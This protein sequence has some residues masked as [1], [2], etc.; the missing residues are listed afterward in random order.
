MRRDWVHG[1]FNARKC[2]RY[3]RSIGVE[4]LPTEVTRWLTQE[5]LSRK[6]RR[7]VCRREAYECGQCHA[8]WESEFK[9]RPKN[10]CC[11]HCGAAA[12]QMWLLWVETGDGERRT[13]D[14]SAWGYDGERGPGQI[15]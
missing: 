1:I 5:A 11:P 14:A 9:R 2:A 10:C 8:R 7:R 12:T 4:L 13:H 3:L 15:R 6:E